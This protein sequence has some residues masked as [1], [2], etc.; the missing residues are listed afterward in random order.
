MKKISIFG[1]FDVNIFGLIFLL[2][3]TTTVI[4]GGSYRIWWVKS[5]DNYEH[6]YEWDRS[7]GKIRKINHT[8]WVK[9]APLYTKVCTIDSRPMQIRIEANFGTNGSSDGVNTRVLNAKLVQFDPKGA[10]LFFT[11]HGLSDY[12]Q[13]S[14][15]EIL[16]I[17]AYEG[18]ATAN[19]NADSLQIKYPFLK[20]LGETAGMNNNL[21]IPQKDSL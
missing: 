21:N 15:S 3:I 19:Y 4:V 16:K 6:A 8:G 9:V 2:L 10:D 5:V 7:T 18:A 14:L 13:K 1:L 20:I 11:Y 17:Y 12:D